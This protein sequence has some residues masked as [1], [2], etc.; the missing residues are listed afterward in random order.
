MRICCCGSWDTMRVL[1]RNTMRPFVR[2]G[3]LLVALRLLVLPVVPAE[4]TLTQTK[5]TKPATPSK[6]PATS[7]NLADFDA[8]VQR[9]M[10]DWQV[11]GAAI[12]IVK[13]GNILLSKGYG[14]RDVKNNLPVT[15]QTLFPI[16]SITK[17]FTVATLGTLA[18]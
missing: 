2:L 3:S 4:A 15:E 10:R 18:T 6:S 17:S 14:L 5:A 13:D 1:W 8:Y 9:V 7:L 16:A 12:V 11:P